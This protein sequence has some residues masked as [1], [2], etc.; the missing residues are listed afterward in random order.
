MKP[1]VEDDETALLLT[2]PAAAKS[3]AICERHLQSLRGRGVIP[4]VRLGRSVRYDP[5]DLQAWIQ[6]NKSVP[7][8]SQN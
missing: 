5:L 8:C 7:D 2:E 1:N 3:L 4:C 6:S